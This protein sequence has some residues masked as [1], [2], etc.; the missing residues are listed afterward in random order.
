MR[1]GTY[2]SQFLMVFIPTLPLVV[3]VCS[4]IHFSGVV[5]DPKDLK[6]S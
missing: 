4:C 6:V 2:L 5:R 1:S 3:F